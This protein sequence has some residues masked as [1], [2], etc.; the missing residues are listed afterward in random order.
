MNR[1]ASLPLLQSK[2]LKAHLD[3]A[4]SLLGVDISIESE[5][6][7]AVMGEAGAGTSLVLRSIAGLVL[8][9]SGEVLFKGNA[10]E[11]LPANEIAQLGI[12]FVPRLRRVFARMT[13]YENLEVGRRLGA[14]RGTA[15]DSWGFERVFN[16]LPSLAATKNRF[17][18]DLDPVEQK[19]LIIG[20][21]LMGGPEL[22][23]LD[24]P[25]DGFDRGES[26]EIIKLLNDIR[27][28][29]VSMLI[30]EELGACHRGVC[31]RAYILEDGRVERMILIEASGTREDD[32]ELESAPRESFE[33]AG[34]LR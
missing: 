24:E 8:P 31:D 13:V 29:G 4:A 3:G 18:G 10:I 11:G 21:T 5:T 22:I 33:E 26:D 9:S 2:G 28:E 20:R 7:L 15:K 14:D 1:S 17:A 34:S 16:L 30:A 23:L 32:R 19:M 12:G 27:D 25:V 6:A